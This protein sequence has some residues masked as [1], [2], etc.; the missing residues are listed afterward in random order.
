VTVFRVV[1]F[2]LVG[3]VY[4][5]FLTVIVHR[6][7]LRRSIVTPRS[8]CPACGA[9][10]RPFDNIP[11]ISYV[12]LHGR[13][14]NCAARIPVRYPLTE[15]ATAGL[16]AG[17]AV[18]FSDLYVAVVF[19]VF[20]GALL[21]LG[22][23][24]AEHRILPNAIVYPSFV[25]FAGLIVLG[26]LLGRPLS[27]PR[28][29]IG[30]LAYGLPLLALAFVSPGGMGMGDVKLAGFIG[31]VLGSLGL[32]YVAVA[33]GLGVLAGGIGAIAALV[34]GRSRKSAIPFGPYLALGAMASAFWAPAI[35][36][37]YLSRGL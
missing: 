24:D 22:L 3:L 21:A 32:R 17:A 7:P 31:L 5:S 4:G 11:V 28:A 19:A 23:I 27:V 16:C 8:A 35:A 25:A 13:C 14:R 29:A 18:V 12:L 20:L 33:A 2:S 9:T 1:A 26:A 34:L 30:S 36:R 37:A 6:I 10:V 15:L